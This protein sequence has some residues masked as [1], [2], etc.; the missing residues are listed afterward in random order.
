MSF[1]GWPA[2]VTDCGGHIDSIQSGP[3]QGNAGGHVNSGV[4]VGFSK[5]GL[6]PSSLSASA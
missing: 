5:V 1:Q 6:H 4:S 3:L 2:S